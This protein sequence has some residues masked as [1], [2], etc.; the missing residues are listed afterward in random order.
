MEPA[1]PTN[2]VGAPSM[3]ASDHQAASSPAVAPSESSTMRRRRYARSL[4]RTAIHA[5]VQGL[6]SASGV[7]L[8]SVLGWWIQR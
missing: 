2:D 5:F 6:A 4:S 3:T 1:G 7:A 8:V